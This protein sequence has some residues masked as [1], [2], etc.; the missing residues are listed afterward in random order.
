MYVLY[1]SFETGNQSSTLSANSLFWREISRLYEFRY[2]SAIS[3][4]LLYG[5]GYFPILG[6]ALSV[7]L[8][9][10]EDNDTHIIC[11]HLWKSRHRMYTME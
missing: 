8:S 7:M 2:T 10:S 9:L 5:V 6:L 1:D 11:C 3:C 4:P